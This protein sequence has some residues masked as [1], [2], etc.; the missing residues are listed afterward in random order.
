LAR[1]DVKVIPLFFEGSNRSD[2][3]FLEGLQ[4]FPEYIDEE[5]LKDAVNDILKVSLS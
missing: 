2:F 5:N 3:G 4:S 1:K